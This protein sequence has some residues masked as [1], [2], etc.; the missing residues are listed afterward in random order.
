MHLAIT[1]GMDTQQTTITAILT[2]ALDE[3]HW[4]YRDLAERAGLSPA[5]VGFHVLGQKNPEPTSIR[6]Y[7]RAL[8]L[9]E[10]YLLIAAGHATQS[11]MD[12]PP[13]LQA[14]FDLLRGVWRS[15]TPTERQMIWAMA[16]TLADQKGDAAD[17]DGEQ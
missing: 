8:G 5:T 1:C 12:T 9:P 2:A 16:R 13:D 4:S 10:Q 15:M 3:R 11:R 14:V 6:K 17:A 7:A